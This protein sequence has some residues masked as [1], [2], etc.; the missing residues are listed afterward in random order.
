VKDSYKWKHDA[1]FILMWWDVADC[2]ALLRWL[3][4]TARRRRLLRCV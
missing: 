4:G 3:L 1:G 2:L